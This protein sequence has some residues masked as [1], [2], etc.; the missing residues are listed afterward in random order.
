MSPYYFLY[1]KVKIAYLAL[2]NWKKEATGFSETSVPI[3]KHLH[4]V[5]FRK[6]ALFISLP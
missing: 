4:G 2:S 1:F 5:T 3:L 6:T